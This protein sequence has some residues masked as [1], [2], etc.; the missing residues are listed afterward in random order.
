ME[1]NNGLIIILIGWN[2]ITFIMM[3]VDKY[4]SLR[5]RWRIREKTLFLS[6]FL[7]GGIGIWFGIYAFNHKTKH[8]SFRILVPVAVMANLI[9]LYF[10]NS[11]LN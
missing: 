3:G 6:A 5:G 2:L 7:F 4:K 1:N 9:V 11:A 10:V 8:W